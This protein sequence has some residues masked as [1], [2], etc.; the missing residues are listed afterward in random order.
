MKA[1]AS[2]VT[3]ALYGLFKKKKKKKTWGGKEIS[4]SKQPNAFI[5]EN[6]Q[7]YI[8]ILLLIIPALAFS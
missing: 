8:H 3:K 4:K 1:N 5:P 2:N 7:P 6:A